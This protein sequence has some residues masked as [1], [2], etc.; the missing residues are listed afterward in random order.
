MFHHDATWP[1]LVMWSLAGVFIA[2][3]MYGRK[4]MSASVKLLPAMNGVAAS[5]LSMMPSA[6]SS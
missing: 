4:Q 3:S 6:V 5:C 2:Y 1:C